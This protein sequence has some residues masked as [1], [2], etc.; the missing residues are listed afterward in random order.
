[1]AVTPTPH[2]SQ[3]RSLGLSLTQGL[4]A[5]LLASASLPGIAQGTRTLNLGEMLRKAV[6]KRQAP[7]QPPGPQTDLEQLRERY[8]GDFIST[9]L[10]GIYVVRSSDAFETAANLVTADGEVLINVGTLGMTRGIGGPRLTESEQESIMRPL[11]P[12]FLPGK[13]LQF[14]PTSAPLRMIV[15]SAVDCGYC[16]KLEPA[17][18]QKNL[19]Y[20]VIP[21]LLSNE[22]ADLVRRIY[23]AADPS[24]AW[25]QTLSRGKRPTG[26][27]ANCSY[28]REHFWVLSGLLGGSTPRLVF[29]DGDLMRPAYDAAGIARI[30]TKLRELERAGVAFE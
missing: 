17:L 5:L 4:L 8:S 1:M 11:L 7:S 9:K 16:A 30:Q 2:Q 13:M 21:G 14:G 12:H 29:A 22:N 25:L 28:D 24:T 26:G 27:S 23:C 3:R 18:A 15:L 10:P 19:R 6:S 20:A